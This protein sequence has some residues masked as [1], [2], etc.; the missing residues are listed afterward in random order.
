[1]ESSG[2]RQTLALLHSRHYA[3]LVRIAF[4]LTGD[5]PLAED[6]VQEA[7]IRTWRRWDR[8]R[9]VDSAPAYLRTAVV[10][11]SRSSLSR[12]ARE[13][14]LLQS[15]EDPHDLET[16][17]TAT[18]DV[19]RALAQLPHRKRACV[20]L[21]YYMDM[22]E[23]ETA[24]ILGI[25]VGTVKSQT[26]KALQRLRSSLGEPEPQPVRLLRNQGGS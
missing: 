19:L 21:R 5:W 18:A 12:R 7:F 22:S 13:R 10:N 3:E 4:G 11:L 8:I 14:R 6:L 25:S 24:A 20:V 15:F 26:S 23:A 9:N 2:E 16:S 17:V 1:M